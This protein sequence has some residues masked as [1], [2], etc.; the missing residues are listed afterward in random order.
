VQALLLILS[1]VLL[2]YIGAEFLVKGASSLAAALGVSSLLIGL[3]VVAFGTSMPE[4]IVSLNA[5][6]EGKGDIAVGNVVGSNIFNIAFI[7]GISALFCPLKVKVQLVK[8]DVPVMILVSLMAFFF[9]KN[10][11]IDRTEGGV[12][13]LLI[14]AY[15]LLNIHFGRREKET[16]EL[17][18]AL[19]GQ[20]SR[21][22]PFRQLFLV[23]SGLILLVIGAKAL[24]NGSVSLAR[25]LGISEAVIALTI[26]GA[27]TSLPELAT[28]V[29]AA[30]KK[31][32]G[33]CHRKHCRFEYFQHPLHTGAVFYFGSRK[34][35]GNRDFGSLFYA[36]HF[37]SFLAAYVVKIFN[38]PQRGTSFFRN[39]CGVYLFS[40]K[41]INSPLKNLSRSF[42]P[43]AEWPGILL[44]K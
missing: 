28:S 8:F 17:K 19:K 18:D 10:G 25:N 2:L 42:F 38:K 3:T 43:S 41:E 29:I 30:L 14:V 7:L 15:T 22:N 32:T 6:L 26:V 23:V 31:R 16:G 34:I 36:W 27:G 13:F 1:G 37:N 20:K 44:L 24:V 33:H 21:P 4:F 9:L 5:T 40:Y 11:I 12:F 35:S 39:L